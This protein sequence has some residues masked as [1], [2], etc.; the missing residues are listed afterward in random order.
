MSAVRNFIPIDK[1]FPSIEFPSLGHFEFRDDCLF[2]IRSPESQPDEDSGRDKNGRKEPHR[3]L[4]LEQKREVIRMFE[5]DKVKA[6]DLMEL[7]NIGKTQVYAILKQRNAIKEGFA[8]AKTDHDKQS[9][10]KTRQ[11][12]NEQIDEIVYR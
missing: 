9:K 4:T 6:R 5:E 12:G 3:L 10:R 7:F 1:N 11:T 8:Q 2:E